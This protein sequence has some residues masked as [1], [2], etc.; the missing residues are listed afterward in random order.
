MSQSN[1]E[2]RLRKVKAG[3]ILRGTSLHEWCK[4]NGVWHQNARRA[5]LGHWTGPTASA[6]VKRLE[7]ESSSKELR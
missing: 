2:D 6:L 3:F 1:A 5:L 4:V 7:L